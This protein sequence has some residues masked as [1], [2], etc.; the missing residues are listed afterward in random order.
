MIVSLVR[1]ESKLPDE[2]V[3][4]VFEDRADRYRGVP[5]L[6]EKLYLRFGESGEFGAVYVWESEDDLR[7]FR[8]TELAR[9]IP[10]VYQVEG[11]ASFELADV[12]LLVRPDRV[13]V[14]R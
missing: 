12:R 14:P 5:G 13:T 1:F 2:E 9:T 6:V 8:E 10:T 4:A 11:E 3:Q 7:R